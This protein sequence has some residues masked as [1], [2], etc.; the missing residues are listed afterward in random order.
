MS[1]TLNLVKEAAEEVFTFLGSGHSETVYE[2]ALEVE[3]A[4]NNVGPIRRQ[5]PCPIYYKNILVGIGYIDVLIGTNLIVEI[6]NV[7]KITDKDKTQLR[8]Y[9]VGTEVEDGLLINFNPGLEGVE[10]WVIH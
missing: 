6:K 7:S 5:V 2:A 9:L 4:L 3:L 1:D 8:K 10:T